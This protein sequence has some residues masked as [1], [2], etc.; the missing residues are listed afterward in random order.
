MELARAAGWWWPYRSAV[1]I[2][3]RPVRLLQ[4]DRGLLHGEGG[5]AIVYPD[6]WS[7]WAWHG[8]RVPRRVIER[9][10]AVPAAE[11]LAEPDPEVRRVMIERLGNDRFLRDAGATRVAE[12]ETGILWRVDLPGDEPLVCV[13]V[14]CPNP[15]PDA[16]FQRY[17]LRVPPD[18]RTPREAVAWTFALDSRDYRPSI[19]T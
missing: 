1:V 18:M 5:P 9:P 16:A 4:D 8:V 10:E 13:E 7:I 2:C 17:V 15:V 6:G 11:V 14:T 19:E 12:D 3:E